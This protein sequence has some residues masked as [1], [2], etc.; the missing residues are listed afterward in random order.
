MPF[1]EL[2]RV[3]R[4]TSDPGEVASALLEEARKSEHRDDVALVVVDVREQGTQEE[5]ITRPYN[6]PPEPPDRPPGTE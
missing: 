5:H 6:D 3:A 4:T 2:W 1:D